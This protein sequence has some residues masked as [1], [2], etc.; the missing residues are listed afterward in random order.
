MIAS[1]LF[2][3]WAVWSCVLFIAAFLRLPADAATGVALATFLNDLIVSSGALALALFMIG[4][5]IKE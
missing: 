5:P 3:T 1:R 2:W 4:D